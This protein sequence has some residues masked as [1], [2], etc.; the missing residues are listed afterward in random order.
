MNG[1]GW[2]VAGI[3]ARDVLMWTTACARIHVVIPMAVNP[4]NWSGAFN[5]IPRLR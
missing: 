2:P 3:N 4:L 5:A 1:N